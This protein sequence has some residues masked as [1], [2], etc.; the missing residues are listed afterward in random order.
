MKQFNNVIANNIDTIESITSQIALTLENISNFP[1]NQ[2][3]TYYH[4]AN[5]ILSTDYIEPQLQGIWE[6]RVVSFKRFIGTY[7][8]R[9]GGVR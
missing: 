4:E 5:K 6:G 7:P 3:T 2:Y 9:R 1:F 8:V